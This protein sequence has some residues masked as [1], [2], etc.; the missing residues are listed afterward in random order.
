MIKLA[1]GMM[2]I[3]INFSIDVGNL[4]L[5]IL[6]EFVGYLLILSEVE[7]LKSKSEYFDKMG[8]LLFFMTIYKIAD[9]FVSMFNANAGMV[10][11]VF[12]YGG[13][14]TTF[15]SLYIQYRVIC[16]IDEITYNDNVRA[17][18]RR[19]FVLF[20]IEAV[21]AVLAYINNITGIYN[22][23]VSWGKI[24]PALTRPV[25]RFLSMFSADVIAVIG[26]IGIAIILIGVV[27]RI[28][29]IIFTFETCTDY[30]KIMT[31][32]SGKRN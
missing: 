26:S 17:R 10:A 31:E 1:I 16:G 28:L 2:L 18:T 30:D 27:I 3:L 15:L 20:K 13:I 14:I 25:F 22:N 32:R 12:F 7:K 4:S 24:A 23:Y 9:Y 19:L 5:N 11:T 8:G 6:P 21:L 29:M